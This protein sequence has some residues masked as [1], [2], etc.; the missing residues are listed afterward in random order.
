MTPSVGDGGGVSEKDMAGLTI[1]AATANNTVM[2]RI[3]LIFQL[4]LYGVMHTRA[5]TVRKDTI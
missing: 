3:F 5:V 2:R 4:F 1:A